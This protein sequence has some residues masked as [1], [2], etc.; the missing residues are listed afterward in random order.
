MSLISE[1]FLVFAAVLVLAFYLAPK[2]LQWVLLLLA[3]CV[4]Y[5]AA[6]LSN[7]GYIVITAL[8]AYGAGLVL[9][10][11]AARG[12]AKLQENKASWSKE[13]KKAWKARVSTRRKWVMA[14]CLVL[15]FGLLCVF[16]YAGFVLQQVNEL[17][18]LLGGGEIKTVWNLITPLG[19]SFYTFQTMGYVVDVYWEMCPA[20]RNFPK[21][22]LFT[23]F[24]PQVT[25]GPIS[26]YQQLS[27]QLFAQHDF[28]DENI[29]FGFQ[30]MLW[31]CLLYTSRCV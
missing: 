23:S 16:K 6:G 11:L 17:S 1:Q 26:D 7:C 9:E 22:L 24:F 21:L 15:N 8:S 27:Q 31:G 3:S 28:K 30:R 2:R 29:T 12:K 10:K 20:Q 18:L 14:G 5:A 19:I 13:E 4:F 25:Q